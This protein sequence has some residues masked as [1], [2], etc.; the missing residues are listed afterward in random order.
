MAVSG[1][2]FVVSGPHN[3]YDD[4]GW[5]SDEG[6]TGLFAKDFK[7]HI[8]VVALRPGADQGTVTGRLSGKLATLGNG[9]AR[10]A[11]EPAVVP[12]QLAEVRDLRLLPTLLGAFLVVLAIGAVGH[13][14]ATAVRRR[15]HEVAVMRA[16]GMTRRQTRGVVAT[17]ASVLAAIGLAFGAPVGV[18]LGRLLWRLVADQTPLSYQPPTAAVALI[19]IGPV[20]LAAANLLAIWPARRAA[21]LPIGHV[22]RTE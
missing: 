4:G 2:G 11:V 20:V 3:D 15:R 17:Q 14:L 13:A 9:G 22:L 5:V 6:F 7:Y 19:V 21:R 16:L 1:I 8:A 12:K 18:V 10:I